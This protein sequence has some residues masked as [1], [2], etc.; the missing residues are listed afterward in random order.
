MWWKYM[1]VLGKT[2]LAPKDAVLEAKEWGLRGGEK[3]LALAPRE[4][5]A[6]G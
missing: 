2:A 6:R 3:V 1:F 4:D 5:K